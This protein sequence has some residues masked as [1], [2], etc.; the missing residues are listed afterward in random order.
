MAKVLRM[1]KQSKSRAMKRLKKSLSE[2]PA[3]EKMPRGSSEFT[4]WN[5][6]TKVAIAR[7]FGENGRHVWEFESISFSPISVSLDGNQEAE[8]RRAYVE[9][10]KVAGSILESMIEEFQEY[11]EEDQSEPAPAPRKDDVSATAAR[12]VFVIHGRDN[13]AKQTVARFLQGLELDPIILHEQA[14]QGRTIIEKLENHDRVGFAVALLTPD[15]IGGLQGQGKKLKPRARQNVIFEFGYFTGRLGRER[16]CALVK[17]DVDRPSDYDG[18]VYIRM[19][20]SDGWKLQLI[21]EL[22]NAG[23]PVDANRAL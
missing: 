15:D 8:N 7:T 11:W 1:E 22:K 10:L 21:R 2:I 17:D 5:R 6:N 13:D 23:F 4:K 16:V 3:L 12:E 18:V 19:D 14:N 20:D 9:G